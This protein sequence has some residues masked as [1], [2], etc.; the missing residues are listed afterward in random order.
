MRY[1]ALPD[2]ILPTFSPSDRPV[3]NYHYQL[4]RVDVPEA[5]HYTFRAVGTM[6]SYAYFYDDQFQSSSPS[7]NLITSNDDDGADPNFRFSV[8]LSDQ[9][10]YYL[11][12]TWREVETLDYL[13]GIIVSGPAEAL[14]T[15]TTGRFL[16]YFLLRKI[17]SMI[18]QRICRLL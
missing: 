11:A 6:D 10:S 8:D 7:E 12:Y 2:V 3:G 13:L 18:S 1:D 4:F 14:L 5:G 9:I 16:F 17:I 15:P